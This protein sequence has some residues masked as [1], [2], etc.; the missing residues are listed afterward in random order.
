[1][2]LSPSGRCVIWTAPEPHRYWIVD[3]W[4]APTNGVIR[5]RRLADAS[6]ST[7]NPIT[8]WSPG[9]HRFAYVRGGSLIVRD[10]DGSNARTVTHVG[11]GAQTPLVWMPNGSAVVILQGT[12]GMEGIRTVRL[13]VA[14]LV[15][16][17]ST[18]VVQF[19]AWISRPNGV[20]HGSFPWEGLAISADG[21]H[22]FLTT[23]GGGVRVSGVWEAPL[24]GGTAHLILGTPARVRGYPAPAAHL[25][26]ATHLLSSPDFRSFGV[27]AAGGF[28]VE[29][30]R[31]LQGRLLR[32]P[33]GHGCVLSQST[34]TSHAAEIAYVETCALN[35]ATA[36]RSTLWDVPL[37]GGS[38]H[39]RMQVVDRGPDAISLSTVYR[40]VGCGFSMGT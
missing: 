32:I 23:T 25:Q 36:F 3:L 31:T 30:T 34:W 37:K 16:Q 27:D 15:G 8:A 28:W 38:P 2:R 5:P 11:W 9:G 4:V 10:A 39:L 35:G 19:P 6:F 22:V 33:V 26:G 40:C 18:E 13:V 29:D 12:G 24:L 17:S 21:R 14:R 1:V 7:R 20:P